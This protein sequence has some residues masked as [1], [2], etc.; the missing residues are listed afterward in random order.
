MSSSSLT[1]AFTSPTPTSAPDGASP[2]PTAGPLTYVVQDGDSLAGIALR[3]GVSLDDLMKANG[4]PDAN[5][6]LAGQKLIIPGA[7]PVPTPTAAASTQPPATDTPGSDVNLLTIVD[8]QHPLGAGYVPPDVAPVPGDYVAPGY[9]ASMRSDVLPALQQMLDAGAAAGYDIR[10]VS[11]Y[12][13]YDDQVTTYNYWVQQ[14][15]QEEADRISA[16]PGYSEHQLGTTADLGAATYGWDL[17]TGFGDT[18]AGR[19]LA[20]NAVTYGFVMSYPDGKENITGYSYEPWHFRY[21]GVDQARQWQ[22]SGLT[23]NQFLGA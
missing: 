12:R 15:G 18:P 3:F 17:T 14:L 20:T 22:A 10:V 19:W 16:R 2:S 8:K 4:I 5:V 1:P 9:S 7:G 23:L 13:S 6:L 21:I 11:G